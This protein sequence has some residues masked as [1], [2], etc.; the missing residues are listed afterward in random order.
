MPRDQSLPPKHAGSSHGEPASAIVVEAL[1]AARRLVDRNLVVVI[2]GELVGHPVE[3]KRE[4]NRPATALATLGRSV[5]GGGEDPA[6]AGGGNEEVLRVITGGITQID[7]RR[8]WPAEVR[9]IGVLVLVGTPTGPAG[10]GASFRSCSS[11]L[12]MC[13]GDITQ[14]ARMMLASLNG[15]D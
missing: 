4:P 8:P 2:G 9:G 13:P 7:Q 11:D 5:A 12:P 3:V 6:R 15:Q 14:P 1:D 10:G